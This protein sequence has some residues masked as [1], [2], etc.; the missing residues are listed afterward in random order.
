MDA[1]P[2]VRCHW[3]NS[4]TS[5]QAAARN[6]SDER[7]ENKAVRMNTTFW[8]QMDL[9]EATDGPSSE[10][11]EPHDRNKCNSTEIQVEA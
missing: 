5:E 4:T 6:R 9:R 2:W 8:Q 11:S 7:Y 10:A 3:V 1:D